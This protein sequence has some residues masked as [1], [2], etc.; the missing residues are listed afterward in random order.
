MGVENFPEKYKGRFDVVTASGVW[1][2]GHIPREGIEDCHA[3]LKTGGYFVTAMRM[4]YWQ[5]GTE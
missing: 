2:A 1:L 3:C 4:S 5:L